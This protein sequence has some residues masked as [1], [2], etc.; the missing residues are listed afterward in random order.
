MGI[1]ADTGSLIEILSNNKN[2][3]IKTLMFYFNYFFNDTHHPIIVD[4]NLNFD[5]DR[6]DMIQ[7]GIQFYRKCSASTRYIFS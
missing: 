7:D 1:S 2:N 3:T 4:I 5:M 6:E